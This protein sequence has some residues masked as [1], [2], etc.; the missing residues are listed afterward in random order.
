MTLPYRLLL[1]GLLLTGIIFTAS[2]WWAMQAIS[3]AAKANDKEQWPQLVRQEDFSE[4]AN[5]MLSGL[6]Q[7]KMMTGIQNKTVDAIPDFQDSMKALPKAVQ[8]LTGPQGFNH[9]LCGDMLG[10]PNAKAVGTT[11]CWALDGKL[12][13]ESPVQVKVTFSNPVTQWQSSLFLSRVGLFT[14]QA[15]GIELPVQAIVDHY[16]KS[17]GLKKNIEPQRHRGTEI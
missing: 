16:A 12:S 1:I 9:L 14:W 7:L 5:K 11:D 4:Y 17:V 15:D 6:L 10:K 8:Q 3:R 2:P 13:W